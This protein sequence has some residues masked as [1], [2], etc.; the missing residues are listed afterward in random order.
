MNTTGGAYYLSHSKK[1]CIIKFTN[2]LYY[3]KNDVISYKS[4]DGTRVIAIAG[5]GLSGGL[6]AIQLLRKATFRLQVV[7]IEPRADLGRGVAYSTSSPSHLLHVRAGN[8]SIFPDQ[9]EDFL[10]YPGS[11]GAP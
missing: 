8:M 4:P 5:G 11:T 10:K 6:V 3:P 1:H 7:L 9:P 2:R